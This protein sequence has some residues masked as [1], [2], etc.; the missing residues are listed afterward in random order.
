M[1][2]SVCFFPYAQSFAPPANERNCVDAG[3][4]NNPTNESLMFREFFC[5][6]PPGR[7]CFAYTGMFVFLGHALFKAYLKKA[8]NDW[9]AA[10]YDTLQDTNTWEAS[11]GAEI[12]S[13]S[14]ISDT[15]IAPSH[16]QQTREDVS[17]H[18]LNFAFL[19]APAIVI[20]PLAKWISSVWRFQWRIALVR[21]YLVH[22]D[23][24][25]H[26]IEG[27]S[28][29]IHEDTQRLE[30]GVY[31]SGTMILDSVLT[32]V[33]FVPILWDVGK[34]AKLPE[35]DW[36]GWLLLIATLAAWGGLGISAVVGHRLVHLEVQNQRVEAAFRTRLVLLEQTPNAIVGTEAEEA[37]DSHRTGPVYNKRLNKKEMRIMKAKAITPLQFP[38]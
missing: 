34:E 20:H 22:Y 28:Q 2:Q 21:S 30:V 27:A 1:K 17:R 31:T 5:S 13:G 25:S 37:E 4:R 23:V 32:L 8:L 38:L 11:S 7:L 24:S 9:Y 26:P 6:G 10:F 15:G 19:V 18:L 14:G 35:W 36:P 12:T 3:N 16:L 33:V 29:R